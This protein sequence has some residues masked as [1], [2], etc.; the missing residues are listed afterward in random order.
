VINWKKV[1][2]NLWATLG[3][4]NKIYEEEIKKLEDMLFKCPGLHR[5]DFCYS[6]WATQ[7][8]IDPQYDIF[9]CDECSGS[10]VNPNYRAING[11][12]KARDINAVLVRI[13]DEKYGE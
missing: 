4:N 9:V 8:S 12:Q 3:S 2:K 11:A 13:E 1:A 6:L 7:R 5:C 10:E